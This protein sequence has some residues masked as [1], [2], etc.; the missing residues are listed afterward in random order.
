MA[1]ERQP[2]PGRLPTAVERISLRTRMRIETLAGERLAPLAECREIGLSGLRATAAE[3]I[4]PG[5]EVHLQ[6]DLPAG[7]RFETQG[8]VT[9]CCTTL[10]LA[11]FGSRRGFED[12]ATFEIEFSERD[13]ETLWPI[14]T[15][16]VNRRSAIRSHQ[17]R[18]TRPRP[19][20]VRAHPG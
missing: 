8:W 11:P 5:T 1:R 16:L 4:P 2:R 10:H 17:R 7:R 14:A 15:L 20:P 12:D 6:I 3:G 19:Q 9:G 13:P 18:A